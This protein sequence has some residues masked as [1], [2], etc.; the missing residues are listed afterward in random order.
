M[1]LK[2]LKGTAKQVKYA[3]KIRYELMDIAKKTIATYEKTLS[4]LQTKYTH[5]ELELAKKF[6]QHEVDTYK[7]RYRC[8]DRSCKNLRDV[9]VENNKMA[10]KELMAKHEY[11]T[12]GTLIRIMINVQHYNTLKMF[13]EQDLQNIESATWYIENE[14]NE[15]NFLMG[16][17]TQTNF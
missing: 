4:H 5:E 3:E 12:L 7:E 14:K 16:V 13:L 10:L 1:K 17:E 11:A 2:E 6:C 8:A 15:F 9:F